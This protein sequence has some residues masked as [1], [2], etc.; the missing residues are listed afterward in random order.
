AGDAGNFGDV[1]GHGDIVAI[2]ERVEHL[3]EGAYAAFAVE[4]AVVRAGTADGPDAEL[5]GGDG[6]DLTVAVARDQ[7]LGPVL[8]IRLLDEGH[9]EVLAVPHGDDRGCLDALV[10]VRRF[11][12]LGTRR[13]DEAKI[14]RA[15]RSD[16][17]L[18]GAGGGDFT[19]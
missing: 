18:H 7:H 1:R 16:R 10:D 9:Q 6:V 19:G 2:L 3:G 12:H 4:F 8:G 17:L 13:P 14:P 15:D 11:E 5:L